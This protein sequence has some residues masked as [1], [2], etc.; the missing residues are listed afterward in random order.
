MTNFVTPQ[1]QLVPRT[2]LMLTGRPGIGTFCVR[3]TSRDGTRRP[4]GLAPCRSIRSTER[5]V[6]RDR[7]VKK[8]PVPPPAIALPKGKL[9]GT[10][11]SPLDP[12]ALGA[13]VR[14][15][16][17]LCAEVYVAAVELGLPQPLLNR[18][19]TVAA[20]GST[21]LAYHVD[22]PPRPAAAADA[23]DAGVEQPDTRTETPLPDI[24]LTHRTNAPEARPSAPQPELKPL[25]ERRTVLV[26][27]DDAMMLEVLFR[28]LKRENYELLTALS[29]TEAIALA[30]RHS[31]RIDLLVTDYV[32][33]EMHG[34]QVAE[35]FRERYG[36]IKVLYQTGFS[37]LLFEA[38][39][40]LEEGAAF[41][42]KPFSARG[43]REA[44]RLIL[45]G[46]INP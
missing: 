2:I 26:V 37:D 42:E 44:A 41:L 38:R 25:T 18:L 28:I 20:Q 27:D 34:R 40:E 22:M 5:F 10:S 8:R 35:K 21:P 23:S 6:P 30:E 14:E 24:H 39:D 32:M 15:L 3:L 29:G 33:P 45:F 17:T 9:P 12:D 1:L 31:G 4:W 11:A 46:A 19:W 7:Q 43:L 16:E 13:R 36:D